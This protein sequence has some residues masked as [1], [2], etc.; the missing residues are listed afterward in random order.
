MAVQRFNAVRAFGIGGEI[1]R[2]CPATGYRTEA[3][4]F[5]VL[6][7]VPSSSTSWPAGL[8]SPFA[9]W[10]ATTTSLE[11]RLDVA[12]ILDVLDS[13]CEAQPRFVVRIPLLARLVELLLVKSGV[14]LVKSNTAVIGPYWPRVSLKSVG[15]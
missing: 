14:C 7:I 15:F 3:G 9:V 4:W 12:E 13:R 6:I 1:E 5:W 10:Q 8:L 2:R 11:D